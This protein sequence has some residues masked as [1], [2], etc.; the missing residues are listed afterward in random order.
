[1]R[2]HACRVFRR[3]GRGPAVTARGD[4]PNKKPCKSTSP[5]HRGGL[6]SRTPPGRVPAPAPAPLRERQPQG[7]GVPPHSPRYL[8]SELL[9]GDNGDLLAH[10]LVGVEVIAQAR[11]VL[12]DDDPGRLLH[13]LGTN[14]ALR[15]EKTGSLPA[16]TPLLGRA[17]RHVT[18]RPHQGLRAGA[19]PGRGE[20][21]N[22]P[23]GRCWSA[24]STRKPAARRVSG[25]AGPGAPPCGLQAAERGRWKSIA[26]D[27]SFRPRNLPSWV[28]GERGNR[29]HKRGL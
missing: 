25:L 10:A 15:V 7:L 19:E 4:G 6:R 23:A 29:K 3:A 21:R 27:N 20:E 26:R 5:G 8:V 12:L 18:S 1:M 24:G 11:V 13:G 2:T 16:R 28:P 22:E 14:A 17:R 9:A